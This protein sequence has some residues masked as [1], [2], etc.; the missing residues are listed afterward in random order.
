MKG[1]ALLLCPVEEEGEK[2]KEGGELDGTQIPGA[3]V[4]QRRLSSPQ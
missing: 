1:R 4:D 2:E 3:A